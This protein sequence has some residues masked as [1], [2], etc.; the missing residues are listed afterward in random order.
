MIILYC[1]VAWYDVV[2]RGVVPTVW[3]GVACCA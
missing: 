3:H 1:G 2:W